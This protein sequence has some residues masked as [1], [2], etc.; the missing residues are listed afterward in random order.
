MTRQMKTIVALLAIM[1]TLL[2]AQSG[3]NF[4]FNGDLKLEAFGQVIGWITP[5]APWTAYHA[6]GGP[7]N[8]PYVAMRPGGDDDYEN[9][10]RLKYLWLTPGEKF[11]LSAFI[12]TKDFSAKRGELLLVNAPWYD[13]TGIKKFPANTNGWQK[14]EMDVVCPK[15]GIHGY[16]VVLL[17]IGQRG[18]LDVADIRLT[19]LSAEAEA[20]SVS[21]EKMLLETPRLIPYG[22]SFDEIPAD[23][24][25]ISFI[26]HG[27]IDE[28]FKEADWFSDAV[29]NNGKSVTMQ[30][31]FET[32]KPFVLPLQGIAKGKQN[33]NVRIVSHKDGK[34]G[35]ME[36]FVVNVRD[37]PADKDVTQGVRL[38]N[39]TVELANKPIKAGEQFSFTL[40][41]DT[42]VYITLKDTPNDKP[43]GIILDGKAV[44]VDELTR[45]PEAFRLLSAGT[46][47]VSANWDDTLVI[48]T[49]AELFSCGMKQG[50]DIAI[51][52]PFDWEFTK[53]Y[54]LKAVTT[55]NRGSYVKNGREFVDAAHRT[56]R[57]WL[58]DMY[59]AHCKNPEQMEKTMVAQMN[60][61][62]FRDGNTTNELDYWWDS[63]RFYTPLLKTFKYDHSKLIYTWIGGSAPFT[64]SM[65]QDFIG[66]CLN[67]S[68]GRGKILCETYM[69]T[70][71][72]EEAARKEV[73]DFLVPN[74][75]N[76][77][78][79]F[80]ADEYRRRSG[81]ILG[82]F[83]QLNVITV[84]HHPQVDYKYFLDMQINIVA[85][86]PI[87]KGIGV[88][89]YWGTHYADEELYRWSHELLRH[90]VVEG[91]KEML[92]KKYGFTYLTPHIVNNDFSDGLNVWTIENAAEKSVTTE[93]CMGYASRSQGRYMVPR[94]C[95]DTVCVMHRQDGK[96]NRVS[97]VAKDLVPG[98]QYMLL[99][100]VGD[101]DDLKAKEHKTRQDG[102]DAILENAEI[103]PESTVYV[104]TRSKGK[105]DRN[106]NVTRPNIHRIIFKP[107]AATMK[108]TFTDEKAKPG[109]NL[110]FN[111][112]QVKPFFPKN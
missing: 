82:N 49:I 73:L 30:T 56:G 83:N 31:P 15:A 67:A 85:N 104:D 11:H 63:M 26:W 43:F 46:H 72:T 36:T 34:V 53:K 105:Y 47:T 106:H 62:E 95:G 108:I 91:K 22:R 10:L 5:P 64:P 41:H 84:E 70:K 42:W 45:L 19:A 21:P 69:F 54:A 9:K 90:Y 77:C 40:A 52:P 35:Y 96:A 60:K 94:G 92:S 25:E 33:I 103:L 8:M 27:V 61:L 55:L 79:Y 112:V 76:S 18:E 12:R 102:F 87:F 57:L 16:D 66:A 59:I 14:F 28:N 74:I 68:N 44:G 3:K 100:S 78:N 88:L 39:F 37:I 1:T 2:L 32:G 29:D 71:A 89:G 48:R 86:E 17:L 80:P 51:F 111:Y 6:D 7:N 93:T 24:P 50:P 109:E 98:K 110:M 97:Q 58:E 101:Y 13:E 107:K 20:K 23:K 65:H 81:V 75:T 38:N 4:A 99:F